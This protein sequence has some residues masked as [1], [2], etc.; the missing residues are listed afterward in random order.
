MDYRMVGSSEVESL[1]SSE[2]FLAYS[3]AYL[4]SAAHLCAVLVES[5]RELSYPRGA[6]VMYLLYHGIELFLKAAILKR[7]KNGIYLSKAGH[8]LEKL[9]EKYM[10]L[11]PGKEYEFE[12]PFGY[13][14]MEHGIQDPSDALKLKNAI[15][16]NKRNNPAN[17]Q[18]RYPKDTKGKKWSGIYAFEPILFTNTIKRTNKNVGS[19]KKLIFP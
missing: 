16:K 6:V 3:E 11:Y 8:N 10:N 18:Y 7:V 5:P 14:E 9:Y 19:L 2:Q 13:E 1:S 15:K 4:N 12:I 17:Q